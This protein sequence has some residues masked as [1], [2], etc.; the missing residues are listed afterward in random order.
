[1]ADTFFN[2]GAVPR[3][4]GAMTFLSPTRPGSGSGCGSG[5]APA[6]TPPADPC[7]TPAV[8]P[9]QPGWAPAAP[10][11][12]CRLRIPAATSAS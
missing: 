1:V 6:V 5:R 7:R 2:K 12:V 4:A 8:C 3:Y 11:A 9:P 10:P